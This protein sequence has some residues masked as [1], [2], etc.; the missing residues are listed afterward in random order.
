MPFQGSYP[1]TSDPWNKAECWHSGR[2]E[3]RCTARLS[4][5]NDRCRPNPSGCSSQGRARGLP[6]WRMRW[7][8]WIEPSP[9]S[10]SVASLFIASRPGAVL[11]LRR[12]LPKAP[13]MP[14]ERV[15]GSAL[16]R[17]TGRPHPARETARGSPR[18]RFATSRAPAGRATDQSIAA[19]HAWL[20]VRTAPHSH[21]LIA[22]TPASSDWRARRRRQRQSPATVADAVLS[23]ARP[24]WRRWRLMV[25]GAARCELRRLLEATDV[26]WK[27]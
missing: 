2:R 17:G 7:T 12:L 26:A 11:K 8:R 25:I 4:A 5:A 21:H 3:R 9:P 13:A 1:G 14:R 16:R 10:S 6:A 15:R 27:S 20:L 18:G 22:N 23:A 19:G 24:R